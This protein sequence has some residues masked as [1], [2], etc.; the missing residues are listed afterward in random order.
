MCLLCFQRSLEL[1]RVCGG[2]GRGE[3]AD[4]P[5]GQVRGLNTSCVCVCMCVCSAVDA[6]LNYHEFVEASD[7]VKLQLSRT[8]R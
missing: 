5:N 3:A 2:Q 4:E 6:C 7:A 8:A 1:P